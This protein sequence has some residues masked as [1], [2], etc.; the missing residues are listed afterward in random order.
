MYLSWSYLDLCG[1]LCICCMYV[2]I[3]VRTCVCC[4]YV[5]QQA[6]IHVSV[7]HIHGSY[8]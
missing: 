1:C 7:Y 6:C 8:V 5:S 3:C 2:R 4:F